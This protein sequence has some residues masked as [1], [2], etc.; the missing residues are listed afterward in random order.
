MPTTEPIIRQITPHEDFEQIRTLL[1]EKEN[2]K[3]PYRTAAHIQEWFFPSTESQPQARIG[4][5]AEAGPK[6]IAFMGLDLRGKDGVMIYA[7]QPSDSDNM[8]ILSDLLEKCEDVITERGGTHIGYFAFTEFGQ[9]RNR[10]I[11][12]L[13]RLGFRTTDEYM[14]ISTR[15]S[16][17]DWDIPEGLNT[18]NITVESIELDRVCQILIDDGNKQN[19]AIFRHQFKAKD[20][21]LVFLSLRSD[22][23]PFIALAYYK[24]KRVNPTSDVLSATA[25]NLHFRPQFALSRQEKKQFLQGVLYSMKQLDLHVVHSLMS[26]KHADIFTLM[27]REGFDDIRSNFFAL[28][29]TIGERK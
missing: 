19:A 27:V 1:T 17:T 5:I 20:P 22:Q 16:L 6:I 23:E 12:T 7:I 4:F 11:F 21:S 15:L 25:F 8:R 28:T 14:R 10:E 29:K 24:V 18:D 3:I 13:E 26:L 9:L 2:D